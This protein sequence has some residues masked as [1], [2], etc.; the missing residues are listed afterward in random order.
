MTGASACADQ[1][2]AF[3]CDKPIFL[4]Y[5]KHSKVC[6]ARE[7]VEQELMFPVR[8]VKRHTVPLFAAD[9]ANSR[10]H[11]LLTF[12]TRGPFFN[13]MKISAHGAMSIIHVH[14]RY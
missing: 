3:W 7:L 2:G 14:V 11:R 10:V 9:T 5:R 12:D 6:A 1:V 13:S 4:P 8:G